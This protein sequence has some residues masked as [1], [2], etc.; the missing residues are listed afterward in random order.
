MLK[1]Y[2]VVKMNN[3]IIIMIIIII[4]ITNKITRII[5]WTNISKPTC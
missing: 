3:N 5:T 2:N 4:I 1:I